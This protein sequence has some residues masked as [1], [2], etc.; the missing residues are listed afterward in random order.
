ML[1]MTKLF[2]DLDAELLWAK[3]MCRGFTYCH[4]K[5]DATLWESLVVEMKTTDIHIEDTI[6]FSNMVIPKKKT[7]AK[8]G[9]QRKDDKFTLNLLHIPEVLQMKC[10]QY[11]SLEDLKTMQFVSRCTAMIAR[12]PPCASYICFDTHS[13]P[14]FPELWLQSLQTIRFSATDFR[15]HRLLPLLNCRDLKELIVNSVCPHDADDQNLLQQVLEWD[16]VQVKRLSLNVTVLALYPESFNA[17]IG[18]GKK[19]GRDKEVILFSDWRQTSDF[20]LKPLAVSNIKQLTIR[21]EPR[22]VRRIMQTV[23]RCYE[24]AQGAELPEFAVDLWCRETVPLHGDFMS[25]GMLSRCKHTK[26][27]ISSTHTDTLTPD[28]LW[29]IIGKDIRSSLFFNA[30]YI[31]LQGDFG[32]H[33]KEIERHSFDAWPVNCKHTVRRNIDNLV[34]LSKECIIP[35]IDDRSIHREFKQRGINTI[36]I[37]LDICIPCTCLL[38]NQRK[39]LLSAL[40]TAMLQKFPQ[41]LSVKV[42]ERKYSHIKINLY[43]NFD[44]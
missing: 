44:I 10:F 28:W 2:M 4:D 20:V 17:I 27:N 7:S 12:S 19:R 29:Q 14:R 15:G 35:Y 43:C 41:P 33:W 39:Y 8:D 36:H 23:Q 13:R 42:T 38:P 21:G 26:I 34:Q 11:L 40:N 6:S 9:D 30:I 3:L 37:A 18:G 22:Q 1:K 5:I 32:T 16:F 31:S 25:P 24:Q